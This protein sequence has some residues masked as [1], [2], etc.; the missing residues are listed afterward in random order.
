MG[1]PGIAGGGQLTAEIA[2]QLHARWKL[3]MT[4]GIL[5][6]LTGFVAIIVPAVASVSTAIFV[7]WLLI[8]GAV[9]ELMSAFSS[10]GALRIVWRV[11]VAG[12]MVFAGVYLVTA[13][14]SG[15]F[16]LTVIL[17]AW[18][19][20]TGLVRIGTA[21]AARGEPGAGIVG[22][23]GAITLLLGILIAVKLPSSADWAIGLLLG[24]DFLFAGWGL[25][26]LAL[27]AKKRPAT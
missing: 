8:F 20:A 25:I 4:I 9:L 2:K 6:M 1:N 14:L 7:G 12:L 15:T 27:A 19:F 22:F 3:L 26:A 16:T 10:R 5:I 11:L 23:N 21:I 13:P 17:A 18:F 24:I